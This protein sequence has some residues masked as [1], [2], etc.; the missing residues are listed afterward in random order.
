[1][2]LKF[3]ANKNIKKEYY[4]DINEYI[5]DKKTNVVPSSKNRLICIIFSEDKGCYFVFRKISCNASF[6]H[7]R[8]KKGL[9][10]IDN[11]AIHIAG[12]GS[13]VAFY[14][15]GISTPIKMSNIEKETKKIEYTDL[16]GNK[17]V[18]I[19]EKIKGL[20]F[21]ARILDI[22]ANR[23]FAENFTKTPVKG[24]E[25]LLLILGLISIIMIGISY[26]IIYL[27]R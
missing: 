18:S 11:E 23:K 5:F 8:F 3:R 10:I 4:K 20:K 2:K 26:G 9:Y 17:K 27:F 1:M 14:L 21:D 16:Y 25:F 22:F 7:F 15:E 24:M 19:I 12:N 6:D 13:R